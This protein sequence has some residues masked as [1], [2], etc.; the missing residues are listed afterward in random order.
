MKFQSWLRTVPLH[1]SLPRDLVRCGRRVRP[2]NSRNPRVCA[3]GVRC[4]TAAPGACSLL[5]VCM[6]YAGR[7]VGCRLTLSLCLSASTRLRSAYP[8]GNWC[9]NRAVAERPR[10]V[11]GGTP[12]VRFS[13][14][15]VGWTLVRGAGAWPGAWRGGSSARRVA[16]QLYIV[17]YYAFNTIVS[18]KFSMNP[19]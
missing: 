6:Q 9:K 19:P 8:Y 11:S 14:W 18:Y 5:T 16:V 12:P 2:S 7:V 3:A 10:L 4:G 15:L 13:L 17:L 1:R